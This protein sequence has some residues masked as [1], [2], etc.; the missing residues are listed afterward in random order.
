M[1]DT[2][3]AGVN[4]GGLHSMEEIKILI[5]YMLSSVSE[6][7]PR[8]MMLEI[9]YGGGMANFFDT[10][11]ALDD[12]IA[13][14]HVNESGSGLL[15]VTATGKEISDT[16]FRTLPFTIRERSVEMTLKLLARARSQKDCTVDIVP[17]DNGQTVTCTIKEGETVLL[18]VTVNTADSYQAN[19]I[20]QNFM[21]NPALL[22]RAVV[23]VLNGQ[24]EEDKQSLRILL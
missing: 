12:V 8:E 23:G 19:A 3:T 15:T 11:A 7:V 13:R 21:Q 24:A 2:F 5:C 9:I 4:F 18:S 6:P 16:L 10:G 22:Y 1:A 20:K 17:A 14:N